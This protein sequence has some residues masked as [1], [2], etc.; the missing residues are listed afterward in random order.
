MST[1][2]GNFQSANKFGT[3]K[4]LILLLEETGYISAILFKA[5]EKINITSSIRT[6]GATCSVLF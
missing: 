2:I 5:S 1:N 4:I 6:E 3:P